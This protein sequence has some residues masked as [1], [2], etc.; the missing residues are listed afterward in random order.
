MNSP[1][2]WAT[3]NFYWNN[4]NNPVFLQT[5]FTVF[6]KPVAKPVLK[7]ILKLVSTSLVFWQNL[8]NNFLLLLCKYYFLGKEALQKGN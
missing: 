7:A 5:I 6:D 4:L 2:Q 3:N 1:V 8:W